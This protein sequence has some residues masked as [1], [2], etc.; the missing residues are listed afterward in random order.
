ML[1]QMSANETI[2]TSNKD[3]RHQIAVDAI[4]EHT[5][6]CLSHCIE[7]QKPSHLPTWAGLLISPIKPLKAT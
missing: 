3:T 7:K 4:G 2:S 5:F 1:A 6:A